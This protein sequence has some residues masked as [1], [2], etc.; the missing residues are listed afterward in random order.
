MLD[1]SSTGFT[2]CLTIVFLLI[3]GQG[4]CCLRLV[5]LHVPSV[6]TSG[7]PLWLNCTYDLETDVLYAVKW[8]KN[9]TEFYRYIPRD[10]PSAQI[11]PMPGV[12]VDR[13]KS[14]EGNVYFSTTNLDTEGKYRCEASAEAPS[15]QTIMGEK[16]LTVYVLP[17]DG[18]NIHGSQPRYDIGDIVNVTCKSNPSKPSANLR[19]FINDIEALQE[20]VTASPNVEDSDGLV[21]SV[22]SLSFEV[23]PEL[24]ANDVFSLRCSSTVAQNY[25]LSSEKLIIGRTGTPESPSS[26]HPASGTGGPMI[27]GGHSSYRVGDTVD[28]NCTYARSK[29]PAELQWFVNEIKAPKSYLVKYPLSHDDQ[30]LQTSVLGLS[31]QVNKGH[32]EDGEMHLKCTATLSEIMNMTSEERV[33]GH[34][35]QSSGLHAS[36]SRVYDNSA[37]T[38]DSRCIFRE[39]LMISVVTAVLAITRY[40]S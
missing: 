29:P 40:N 23:T 9:D 18:P 3:Y 10:K 32:F 24:F 34:N 2:P 4:G 5:N 8:Y 25:S 27:I 19:W 38:N 17:P 37:E 30:G 26:P 16:E 6:V 7:D 20:N 21:S 12:F 39:A 35:H 11:Y 22:S 33:I 28:I 36:E 14:S 13:Q 15:F 31:F 1:M